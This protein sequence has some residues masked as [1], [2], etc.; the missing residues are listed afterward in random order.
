MDSLLSKEGRASANS[1][2]HYQS[3]LLL[4]LSSTISESLLHDLLVAVFY[5][6]TMS[7]VPKFSEPCVGLVFKPTE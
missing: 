6:G 7:G 5:L 4:K 2:L 3:S 1:D